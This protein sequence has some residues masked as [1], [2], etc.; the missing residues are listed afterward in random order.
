MLKVIGLIVVF[1]LISVG[2]VLLCFAFGYACG[3]GIAEGQRDAK[4]QRRPTSV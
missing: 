2:I 1:V 4:Q 3:R